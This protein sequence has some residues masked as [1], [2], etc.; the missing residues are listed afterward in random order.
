MKNSNRIFYGWWIVIA[1]FFMLFTYSASPFAVILK[2]L[3]AEFNTGRG[4][5][6]MIPAISSITGGFAAFFIVSRMLHR[7]TPQKFMI[8]GSVVAGVSL[9][10]CSLANS[11]WYLYIMYFLIGISFGM[12]T[13]VVQMALLSKWFIRKRGRAVGIAL[14]GMSFGSLALTPL[15][16]FVAENFGW[17]ATYLLA[18]AILLAVCV[19]LSWLVVKDDPKQMG[20]LPD[21]EINRNKT[22]NDNTRLTEPAAIPNK[23]KIGM[24]SYLKSVPLW[25]IIISFPVAS[26]GNVAITQH[27]YSYVTDIGLSAAVAASAF[28]ITAGLGGLGGF[29]SGWL[30][31][32]ISPRYVAIIS[33]VLSIFGVLLLMRV[34]SIASLWAFVIVFGLASSVPGILLPLVIGD[35][36]G[37][38]SLAEIFGFVNIIFTFGFA[39]GPP[40][41]GYI[42]DAT[43][44]Y[45][46]VFLIVIILY[47][48]SIITMYFIYG[49]KLGSWR[50]H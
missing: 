25:L 10:L 45:S 31:D 40:L 42:F 2:P 33:L 48:V 27:Q 41:A 4:A 32:R 36:Y 19:P 7:I 37:S 47:V 6:S 43:G 20:L 26:M 12:S 34:N 11:L 8:S 5:V 14:T 28:G 38:A 13:A 16:S 29:I 46:L 18:G 50:R 24:T 9:L 30:A 21:G 1:I 15:V 44:S 23:P 3:M 49:S 39:F 35:I 17:R 22:G